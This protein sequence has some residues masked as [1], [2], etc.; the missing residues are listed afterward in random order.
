VPR[1]HALEL[2]AGAGH[3]VHAQPPGAEQAA[4]VR[5]LRVL[6]QARLDRGHRLFAVSLLE[7]LAR[8]VGDRRV[9]LGGAPRAHREGVLARAPSRTA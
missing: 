9:L 8:A 6:A 5:I 4:Q 1:D 7:Q 2:T 3:V